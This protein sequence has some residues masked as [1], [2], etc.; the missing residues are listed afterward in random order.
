[1]AG[2][3]DDVI[4]TAHDPEIAVF[5]FARAVSGEV[6]TRNLRPVLLHVAIG[7]SVDR[8]QHSWPGLANNQ[9]SSR[10][11]GHGLAVHIHDLRHDSGQWARGRTRLGSYRAGYGRDHDVSGF[12]LPPGVDDRAVLVADDF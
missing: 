8:S 10:T 3:V 12:G 2:D 7:I 4:D 5:V 11:I 6:R 9:E 1:M